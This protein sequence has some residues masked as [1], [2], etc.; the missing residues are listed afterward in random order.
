MLLLQHKS[1]LCTLHCTVKH[2]MTQK[3][4]QLDM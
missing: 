4:S 3:R 2:Q 1:L